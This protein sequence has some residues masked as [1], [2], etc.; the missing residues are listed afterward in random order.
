MVKLELR[1][2]V[3]GIALL[4]VIGLVLASGC[5]PKEIKSP[6]IKVS[7]V[8]PLQLGAGSVDYE[9]VFSIYNPNSVMITLDT[10]EWN[11]STKYKTILNEERTAVL[12]RRLLLDDVYIPANTEVKVTSA[13]AVALSTVIGEVYMELGADALKYLPESMQKLIREGQM[14]PDQASGMVSVGAIAC[15][16][17]LWKLIGA[18]RPPINPNLDT[19]LELAV[20]EPAASGPPLWTV[21]GTASFL[22]EAGV[23]EVPFELRWQQAS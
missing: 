2:K 7:G 22:T 5:A 10:L 16:F 13:F 4:L 6:E 18:S 3:I 21:Q 11:I 15:M 8:Y 17:P 1:A 19:Y 9:V 23:V 14:P 20:W 12:A